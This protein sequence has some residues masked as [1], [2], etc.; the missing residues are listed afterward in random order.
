MTGKRAKPSLFLRDDQSGTGQ[1]S[2][3]IAVGL[4]G[5]EASVR[6]AA[7]SVMRLRVLV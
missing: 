3:D 1:S 4:D 7:Y 5:R 2:G 6:L